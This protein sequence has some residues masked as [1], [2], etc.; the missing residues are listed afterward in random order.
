MAAAAGAVKDAAVVGA[1]RACDCGHGVSLS[2]AELDRAVVPRHG[3][4][5]QAKYDSWYGGPW[6]DDQM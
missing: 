3:G 6:D 1:G 2:G 5:Q 4:T